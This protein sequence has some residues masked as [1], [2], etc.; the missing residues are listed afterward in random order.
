MDLRIDRDI[1][2]LRRGRTHATPGLLFPLESTAVSLRAGGLQVGE[3][4]L[5]LDRSTFALIPARVGYQI[6]LPAS[7]TAA[8]VT[9]L[10]PDSIRTRA[11]EDYAPYID[12]GRL[13]EVLASVRVLPRTRWVDELVNRYLFEREVCAKEKSRAALFLESELTKE[14]F[15]LGSEQIAERTRS[16]VL[17]EG[18]PLVVRA[19]AWIEAHMFEPFTIGSILTHCHA[20]EST[21]L[22]A[23]RR[24]LGVTPLA[25]VR[26]RRL[27]E[28]L[29]MLESGRYGVTE[30][31]ARVGYDSASA[32][33]VAFRERFGVTPS[34]AKVSPSAATRLPAHGAP[35]EG[36]RRGRV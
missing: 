19:R 27:E 11:I 36:R 20:S 15:F 25:Y 24:E 29:Q 23:F 28:A 26:Q 8:I 34:R 9:L 2:G 5:R 7:A 35:P 18:D 4:A 13:A 21:L 1:K 3:L 17:F 33:S 32:F 14:V 10:I 12:P 6:E 30:V 31:A 22:R 16:S